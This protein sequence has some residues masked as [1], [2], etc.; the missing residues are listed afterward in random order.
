MIYCIE[1][2]ET[3]GNASGKFMALAG[4][5]LITQADYT[6]AIKFHD[7]DSAKAFKVFICKRWKLLL[8]SYNVTEHQE[9]E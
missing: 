8:N 2:I 3:G 7:I 9:V 6:Q 5:I 4:N 1:F